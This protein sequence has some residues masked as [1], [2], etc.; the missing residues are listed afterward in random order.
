[1]DPG[2]DAQELKRLRREGLRQ[3]TRQSVRE[4]KEMKRRRARQWAKLD[5]WDKG[6]LPEKV[7]QGE[8][9]NEEKSTMEKIL[10]IIFKYL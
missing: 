4:N 6:W 10:H 9:Y 7:G 2:L 3:Q 5:G 8:I 1:M